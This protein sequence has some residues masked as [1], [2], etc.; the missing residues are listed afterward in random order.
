MQDDQEKKAN[1]A[2]F[3]EAMNQH[4][5]D[6]SVIAI[7]IATALQARARQHDESKTEGKELEGFAAANLISN[8]DERADALIDPTIIHHNKNRHHPQHFANGMLGM[9][10]IDVLEMFCNIFAKHARSGKDFNQMVISECSSVL[11]RMF[12]NTAT[13]LAGIDAE[14]LNKYS[15]EIAAAEDAAKPKSQGLRLTSADLARRSDPALADLIRQ[16][17]SQPQTPGT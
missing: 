7:I 5:L 15:A 8:E 10:L 14:F 4:R 11:A 17:R 6:V 13:E 9:T 16:I 3:K 12:A 1:E 2:V